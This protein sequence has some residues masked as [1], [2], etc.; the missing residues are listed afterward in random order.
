MQEEEKNKRQEEEGKTLNN[1]NAPRCSYY[2]FSKS[3]SARTEFNEHKLIQLVSGCPASLPVST[4]ALPT[5]DG[6]LRNKQSSQ[7]CAFKDLRTPTFK[8]LSDHF[9]H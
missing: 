8:I 3:G 4:R 6:P 5:I 2:D 9:I 7:V 1:R